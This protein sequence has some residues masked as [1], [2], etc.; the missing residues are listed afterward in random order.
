M[1]DEMNPKITAQQTYK[2]NI[3][4][5]T[6]TFLPEINGVA[7]TLGR[8]VNELLNNHHRVQIIRPKQSPQETPT[9]EPNLKEYLVG[10]MP[11]PFYRHLKFGYPS[12]NRLIQYWV[13]NRPDIIHIATEGPL[14]WSALQAAKKLRIPV[15][16]SYHTNFH[17]YSEHYGVGLLMKPIEAYLRTFHNQTLATLAPTHKVVNE[18]VSRGYKNVS[19]MARGVDTKQFNPDN[20]SQA[21]R[22]DWGVGQDD[23]AV[24][25]VGRLAKEKNIFLVVDAF[26]AV[27]TYAPSAKLIFVGDGPLK[28]EL[29]KA[30]PHA[31]FTGS[32]QGE[33]LAKHYASADLFLFPSITE[34]FGNVIPEA[35][36][37]G[38]C[39]VAYN[40]AAAG[41]IITDHINGFL[42]PFNERNAFIDKAISVISDRN[43]LNEVREMAF[44]SIGNIRWDNV[45]QAYE[46]LLY[47]T[48]KAFRQESIRKKHQRKKQKILGSIA[49]KMLNPIKP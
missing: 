24:V 33:S 34:T 30:C 38:L 5:V 23:L 41:D 6:E 15:I 39:V 12:K 1:D 2:L 42:V 18:L 22:Q 32:K 28:D 11:I 46:Q 36:A 45:I 48:T 47:R 49:L 7:M 37:S 9:N 8:I 35:L 14:G 26:K 40:Y 31:I 19:V 10:G 27:Q 44:P 4:L 20:R 43:K 3:A 16:S 17:Q 25:H 29:K 13:K 21:L